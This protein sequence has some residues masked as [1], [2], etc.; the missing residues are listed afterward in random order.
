[1]FL[2]LSKYFLKIVQYERGQNSTKNNC[3]Q[4]TPVIIHVFG[5][6]YQFKRGLL[7]KGQWKKR[8]NSNQCY[9]EPKYL[10]NFDLQI[11]LKIIHIV[12]ESC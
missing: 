4:F 5:Y 8:A 2:K 9:T 7:N 1:M 11:L 12:L 10:S 6:G 3:Y